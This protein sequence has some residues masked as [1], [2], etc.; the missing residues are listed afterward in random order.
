MSEILGVLFKYLVAL[1]GVS[2]VVM[3]AYQV[4]GV[5]K[6]QTAISDLTT[7]QVSA[8]A[9]YAGQSSFTTLTNTVAIAAKLAPSGMISGTALTN[10]WGGT[11][12]LAVNGANSS[13]F[14]ITETLVP[15]EA[16]AKMASNLTNMVILSINGANQTLPID[17]GTAATACN[18]ASNT[19]IFTFSH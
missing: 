15:T 7:L 4:F 9:L 14:D 19:M 2:A 12:T 8:Q 1:L 16:C 17:A 18:A 3:V 10:P 13:R 5:N 11:V 6:T